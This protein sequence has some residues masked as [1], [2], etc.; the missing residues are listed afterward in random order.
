MYM[1]FMSYL[2][3][4][5]TKNKKNRRIRFKGAIG[6]YVWSGCSAEFVSI[7]VI[8]ILSLR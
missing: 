5:T 2:Y 1:C 6:L 3:P 4:K 7:V 8:P